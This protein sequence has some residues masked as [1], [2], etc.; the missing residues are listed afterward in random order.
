MH[1]VLRVEEVVVVAPTAKEAYFDVRAADAEGFL[2]VHGVPDRSPRIFLGPDTGQSSR[3]LQA[4]ING[5]S[6]HDPSQAALNGSVRVAVQAIKI[7]LA[8]GAAGVVG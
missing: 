3:V 4:N 6:Q 1:P 8:I 5:A 7:V 2:A